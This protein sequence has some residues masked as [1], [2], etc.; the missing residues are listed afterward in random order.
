MMAT[1]SPTPLHPYGLGRLGRG[2][3]NKLVV[4]RDSPLSALTNS[5][6]FSSGAPPLRSMGVGDD[7]D[8]EDL[9]PPPQ[10][11]AL[12]RSVLEQHAVVSPGNAHRP[13]RIRISRNSSAS[14]TPARDHIT[15]AP[16][17]RVKRVGL[18]GAPVRR[19][20]RTP[21]GED[22]QDP[23]QFDPHARPE[24]YPIPPS[25]DQENLPVA[26]QDLYI[27]GH[28]VQEPV[29]IE[30]GSAMKQKAD[31]AA[32]SY[33]ER[34]DKPVPLAS[35]SVNTPHRPAPPPPPPKMSVLETATKDAGASTAKQKRR[36]T[37]FLVNGKIYSQIKRLGK[38]GS[39]D[40][41]QVMAENSAVYALKRVKLA[42]ADE[43]AIQGYKG[44]IELLKKLEKVDRVVRL[45]DYQVDEEKQCLYVVR[46]S[47]A[48]GTATVLT[49]F[50]R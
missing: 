25:L 44:E 12:G 3:P 50:F 48:H 33:R 28:P 21:Q 17:L 29:K 47:S 32:Q 39:S 14:N 31:L 4:R 43:T 35:A 38:G 10:L 30:Y 22:E 13:A 34:S 24:Q 36:R 45:I 37:H 27:K 5:Q 23:P 15:P 11:S 6:G 42:G 46:L 26:M 40:V 7:S 16:S 8:E 49:A 9:Q 18:Q 19:A 2:Q 41:Y 1:M 20:R